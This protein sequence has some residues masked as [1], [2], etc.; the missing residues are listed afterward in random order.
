[1]SFHLI[2]ILHIIWLIIHQS[3]N[4]Q[5]RK[6]QPTHVL[7]CRPR[8]LI[9][10]INLFFDKLSFD[11]HFSYNM[12]HILP[13][14]LFHNFQTR[15][16]NW[17]QVAHAIWYRISISFLISFYLIC[18]VHILWLIYDVKTPNSIFCAWAITINLRNFLY[19][20]KFASTDMMMKRPEEKFEQNS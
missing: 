19:F 13:I 16:R 17:N 6:S 3:L 11:M 8:K 7:S 18:I 14:H 20:K 4:V 9:T 12:T 2:C 15:L 5:I 1:M 10:Y